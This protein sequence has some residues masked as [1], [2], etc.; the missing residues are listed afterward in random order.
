MVTRTNL[1]HSR[2]SPGRS[3]L[4]AECDGRSGPSQQNVSIDGNPQGAMGACVNSSYMLILDNV[5]MI[6]NGSYVS[7]NGHRA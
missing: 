2:E 7:M 3:L 4:P 1:D 5:T 6:A